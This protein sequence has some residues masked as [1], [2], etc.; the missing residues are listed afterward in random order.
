MTHSERET[1][2]EGGIYD[3]LAIGCDQHRDKANSE[4][5]GGGGGGGIRRYWVPIWER[6]GLRHP[7]GPQAT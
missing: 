7:E 5:N 3:E 4:Y 1:V 6:P 2:L